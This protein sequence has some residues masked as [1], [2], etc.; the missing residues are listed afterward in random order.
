MR[1]YHPAAV[2]WGGRIIGEL[3]REL[4][5]HGAFGQTWRRR[6]LRRLRDS[7]EVTQ[8]RFRIG[9]ASCLAAGGVPFLVILESDRERSQEAPR[10]LPPEKVQLTAR[11][12]G[13]L[14]DSDSEDDCPEDFPVRGRAPVVAS[15]VP[16][17]CGRARCGRHQAC[18]H[19][20]GRAGR[21]RAAPFG[22]PALHYALESGR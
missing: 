15:A 17:S 19:E 3:L 20:C 22:L 10:S 11:L 1:V 9:L 13:T 2:A 12:R 14:R 4:L 21:A 5:Q 18:A 16:R 6:T 7:A 8:R